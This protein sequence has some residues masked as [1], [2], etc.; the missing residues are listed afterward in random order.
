ML[1]KSGFKQNMQF[2]FG[3]IWTYVDYTKDILERHIREKNKEGTLDVAKVF[4]GQLLTLVYERDQSGNELKWENLDSNWVMGNWTWLRPRNKT[5]KLSYNSLKGLDA[6]NG[7]FSEDRNPR[8]P[9]DSFELRCPRR[10]VGWSRFNANFCRVAAFSS[11]R[12]RV[13]FGNNIRDLLSVLR[14]LECVAKFSDPLARFRLLAGN[15]CQ[16]VNVKIGRIVIG[17]TRQSL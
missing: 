7:R 13:A 14:S 12:R 17:R 11:R 1:I 2:F 3:F 10:F 16:R 4:N 6:K 5:A 8:S 15:C 9:Q